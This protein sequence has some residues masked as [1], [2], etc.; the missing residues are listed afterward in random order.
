MKWRPV[1]PRALNSS[2]FHHHGW[3]LGGGGVGNKK[4]P[5]C[6]RRVPWL[7]VQDQQLPWLLWPA[8]L[9]MITQTMFVELAFPPCYRDPGHPVCTFFLLCAPISTEHWYEHFNE[10]DQRAVK[11]SGSIQTP[12][13]IPFLTWLARFWTM[14]CSRFWQS[15]HTQKER[16]IIF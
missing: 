6:C 5:P 11:K 16:G 13:I 4:V 9:V 12:E 8:H 2:G 7:L 3:C 14:K 1:K 15:T 10:E